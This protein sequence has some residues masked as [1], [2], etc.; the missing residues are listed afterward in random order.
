MTRLYGDKK[1]D[2]ETEFEHFMLYGVAVNLL[3]EKNFFLKGKQNA[4][5]WFL[6]HP[7]LF[8][9]KERDKNIAIY[10]ITRINPFNIYKGNIFSSKTIISQ[11]TV[12]FDNI[13]QEFALLYLWNI[14][15]F[16]IALYNQ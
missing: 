4:M 3:F 13:S 7:R 11:K 8:K 1:A 5:R 16:N 10:C 9:K 12:S 15:F 14:Y 6:L 2:R